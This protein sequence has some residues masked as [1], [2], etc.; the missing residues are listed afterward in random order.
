MLSAQSQYLRK[1]KKKK[2]KFKPIFMCLQ[3]FLQTW[4][5]QAEI[6]SSFHMYLESWKSKTQRNYSTT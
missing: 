4:F 2:N 5:W 1:S 6:T 3:I